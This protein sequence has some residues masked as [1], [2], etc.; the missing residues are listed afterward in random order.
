[1]PDGRVSPYLPMLLARLAPRSTRWWFVTQYAPFTQ[2]RRRV[3]ESYLARHYYPAQEIVSQ[4]TARLILYAPLNAPP[5]VIPPLPA[6]PVRFDFGA[7]TLVGYDLDR[8]DYQ[9]GEFIPLSLLWNK[10]DWPTGMEPFDYSVNVALI[11]ADGADV[12]QRAGTPIG[13]FGLMSTWVSGGYYRDNQALAAEVPP[14]DYAL[15]V[16]VYD[17]RDGHKL[18]VT[19][20]G[21]AG[22]HVVLAQI[23]I[24]N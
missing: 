15:W 23:H 6:N 18:P 4:D 9:Q 20:V 16:S 2:G 14:G 7:V 5:D 10:P 11:A 1:A 17:W 13:S 12:A 3:T 8:T 19:G 24:A 22:D 21:A